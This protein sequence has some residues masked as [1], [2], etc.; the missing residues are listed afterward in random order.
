[1]KTL[2]AIIA[3]VCI[4][5]TT[6]AQTVGR[7]QPKIAL[8]DYRPNDDDGTVTFEVDVRM[9]DCISYI[10]LKNDAHK[11]PIQVQVSEKDYFLSEENGQDILLRL[12]VGTLKELLKKKEKLPTELTIYSKSGKPIY[13]NEVALSK[14]DLINN[15]GNSWR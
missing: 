2:L 12:P 8:K 9:A 1:M 14:Y 15:A 5:Y 3:L 6:E 11:K 4:G 10:E 7:K 13:T